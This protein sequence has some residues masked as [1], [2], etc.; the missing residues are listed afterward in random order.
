LAP[1]RVR[2][3]ADDGVVA[4]VGAG[5]YAAAGSYGTKAQLSAP[6]SASSGLELMARGALES[7]DGD[8]SAGLRKMMRAVTIL[9][10]AGTGR[11]FVDSPAALA[12][13]KAVAR[14]DTAA[15]ENANS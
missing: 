11:Q 14:R 3:A 7:L 13:I 6:T 10:T 8:G 4:A 5:D 15:A 1:G 9:R 12:A 2:S